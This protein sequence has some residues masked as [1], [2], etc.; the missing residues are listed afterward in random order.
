MLTVMT[1]NSFPTSN[2]NSVSVLVT[3]SI[4]RLVTWDWNAWPWVA[5]SST[6]CDGQPTGV[7]ALPTLPPGRTATARPWR[8]HL[9]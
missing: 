4:T 2:F 7:S 8:A 9:S 6:R 1:S 5:R 3:P